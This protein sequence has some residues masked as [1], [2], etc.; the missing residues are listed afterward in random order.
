MKRLKDM[1]GSGRSFIEKYED[2]M[3]R[4]DIKMERGYR[5]VANPVR[6]IS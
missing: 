2:A 3:K 5:F 6:E 1:P 4:F